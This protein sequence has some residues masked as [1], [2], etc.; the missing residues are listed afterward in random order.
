LHVALGLPVDATGTTATAVLEGLRWAFPHR[1]ASVAGSVGDTVIIAIA[2]DDARRW[3]LAVTEEGAEF[4]YVDAPG[5]RIVARANLA[6]DDAWRLLSNN[7]A[8]AAQA[9]LDITGDPAVVHVLLS[10]RAIVGTPNTSR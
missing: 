3:I 5:L 6:A 10:T 1:L 8:P 9:A 4:E 7:L 2:G